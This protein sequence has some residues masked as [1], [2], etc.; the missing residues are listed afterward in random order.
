MIE[1][2]QKEERKFFDDLTQQVTKAK[3]LYVKVDDIVITIFDGSNYP[4]WKKRILKFL[5]FKECKEVATREKINGD[6]E[7]DWT[8]ANI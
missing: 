6:E 1:S 4:N 7:P 3:M 8:N 5:E 2:I